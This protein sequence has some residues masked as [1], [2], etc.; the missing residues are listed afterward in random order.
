MHDRRRQTRDLEAAVIGHRN[1][2]S[3]AGMRIALM[4]GVVIAAMGLAWIVQP[5]VAASCQN[6][7]KSNVTITSIKN[8]QPELC[9]RTAV[10][11]ALD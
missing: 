1:F 6:V 10:P 5:A 2:A 9:P 7:H 3:L 11:K 8:Q 4:S